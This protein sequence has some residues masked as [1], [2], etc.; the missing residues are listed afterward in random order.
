MKRIKSLILIFIII[1]STHALAQDT[2]IIEHNSIEN[3]PTND[4]RLNPAI[5][6]ISFSKS[7]SA[8]ELS[9]LIKYA[10]SPIQIQQG[11][12]K[13]STN[14]KSSTFLKLSTKSTVWG[15]LSYKRTKTNNIAWNSTSDYPMLEPYVLA[16]T[17][18]NNNYNEKYLFTGGY[19]KTLNKWCVGT[20]MYFR[21]EQDWRIRDPRM[22]GI[23]SEFNLKIGSTYQ[24]KNY[25]LGANFNMNIYKQNNDVNI[26]NELGGA[27][28]FFMTGLGTY[29]K[30]FSTII[31]AISYKGKGFGLSTAIFPINKQGIYTN[32]LIER[33]KYEAFS[34][35]YN[36]LPLTFL[37]KNRFKSV[38]V[39]RT[40]G[41]NYFNYYISAEY[42]KK[43]G[44]E[45][46]V[47]NPTA[48]DY[49]VLAT[50]T[51]YKQ[52]ITDIVIGVLYTIKSKSIWN[53]NQNIGLN[54]NITTYVY[55]KRRCNISH[56]TLETSIQRIVQV[57]K[58]IIIDCKLNASLY[59]NLYS[60]INIPLADMEK[61][62]CEMVI[63][64]YKKLS[65]NMLL[66]NANIAIYR[67]LKNKN[68]KIFVRLNNY[69]TTVNHNTQHLCLELTCGINF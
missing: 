28:E 18:Q 51:M 43:Y 57:N 21:A 29:N 19:A 27:T 61:V 53:F 69:F 42:N 37:Y 41:I 55:P 12:N 7:K 26:Y 38:I 32:I 59:N 34:D 33:K 62:L 16:D 68:N 60:T 47:G 14:A 5:Y 65:D 9:S 31:N 44:N 63:Y 66:L 20:E 40:K 64:N 49:P 6:A 11:T 35:A 58:K 1:F 8:L 56:L 24:F 2:D 45:N 25:Y 15:C 52:S 23:V 46:I 4:I 17:V 10:S 3:I 50:L 36:S 54:K 30:R 22:R 13:L 48:S 39:Y 67:Q